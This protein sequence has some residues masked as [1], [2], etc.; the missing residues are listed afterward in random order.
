ML[1]VGAGLLPLIVRFFELD[2]NSFLL[3]GVVGVRPWAIIPAALAIPFASASKKGCMTLLAMLAVAGN[4]Y[5]SIPH[6]TQPGPE[7]SNQG[8][9]LSVMAANLLLSSDDLEPLIRSVEES[10]PDL[11]LLMEL[12]HSH[13]DQLAPILDDTYRFRIIEP[14]D[15]VAGIGLWSTYPMAEA[16]I[17]TMVAG[18][19][20]SVRA[21]IEVGSR[22]IQVV[23]IHPPP[24]GSAADR[25]VQS[26]ELA[27]IGRMPRD[28]PTIVMGDFN[29]SF[30]HAVMRDLLAETGMRDVH[31]EAGPMVPA[32]WPNPLP[33]LHIDH[34]LVTHEF[35]IEEAT[36]PTV[37]W[38][39]DHRAV[40]AELALVR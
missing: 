16:A 9:D 2:R 35:A 5:W 23:G 13:V 40:A 24:P 26:T 19:W 31:L 15:G 34:I 36:I 7:V 12:T 32:T 39:G 21:E 10:P 22:A 28:I 4:I 3:S 29:A 14:A 17:D 20:P 33:L 18:G 6:L 37:Q 11:L 8:T 27:I 30:E 38:G 25:R 1:L